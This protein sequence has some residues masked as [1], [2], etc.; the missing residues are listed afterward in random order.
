MVLPNVAGLVYL[1]IIDTD[2]EKVPLLLTHVIKLA[3]VL[4]L[5]H[6][7]FQI[8]RQRR[9]QQVG[10]TGFPVF[11]PALSNRSIFEHLVSP[12]IYSFSRVQMEGKQQSSES[13]SPLT[14]FDEFFVLLGYR[15]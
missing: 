14:F 2:K 12:K 15:L 3:W 13:L 11:K 5:L 8:F 10:K 1:Q 4:Q 9:I 6:A 7:L